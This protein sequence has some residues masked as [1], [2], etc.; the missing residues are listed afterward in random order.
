MLALMLVTRDVTNKPSVVLLKIYLPQVSYLQSVVA[1]LSA[2]I[3]HT[4]MWL[5]TAA[6]A[7]SFFA[8]SAII[9]P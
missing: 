8:S 7:A 9:A 4:W 6:Y 2:F 3:L 5:S 1:L